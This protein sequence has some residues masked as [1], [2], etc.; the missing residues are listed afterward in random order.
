[1]TL[2]HEKHTV[3]LHALFGPATLRANFSATPM[4]PP[5]SGYNTASS[6]L[7]G[8]GLDHSFGHL[9]GLR[10]ELDYFRMQFFHNVQNSFRFAPGIVFRFAGTE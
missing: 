5:H 7:A 6:P 9:V 1:M 10:L 8:G 4:F 3:F 2:R